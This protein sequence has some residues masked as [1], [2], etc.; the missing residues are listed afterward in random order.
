MKLYTPEVN[1]P[2]ENVATPDFTQRRRA[3]REPQKTSGKKR[4]ADPGRIAQPPV[5]PSVMIIDDNLGFV[6]W[7][8]EIL[9][10]AGCTVVPALN[11]EDAVA[12]SKQ[13]GV[14]IDLVFINPML[15]GAEHI[16]EK[17]GPVRNLV[18]IADLI[19][20]TL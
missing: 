18:R 4:S 3:L 15:E 20:P 10:K 2:N 11:C 9:L 16:M 5:T 7:L 12:L 14:K 19:Q 13:T 8:G 1:N 17:L 6:W